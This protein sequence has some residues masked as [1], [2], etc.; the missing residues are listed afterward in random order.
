[1]FFTS[2][3]SPDLKVCVIIPVKDEEETI[4]DCLEALRIQK[5]ESDS[6][7]QEEY[8]V[9]ILANNCRD[10]TYMWIKEYQSLY[11]EFP[12]FVEEIE[13]TKERANI[14]TARRFLMDIAYNRFTLIN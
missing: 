6:I 1:M 11:P 8:E 13:F 5:D 2:A 12:L 10:N 9:L 3:P 4:I 7:D 14:G